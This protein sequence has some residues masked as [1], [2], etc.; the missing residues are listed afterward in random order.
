MS[1]SVALVSLIYEKAASLQQGLFVKKLFFYCLIAAVKV[2][3]CS[4]LR[5]VTVEV[6]MN[7]NNFAANVDNFVL[8]VYHMATD[9]IGL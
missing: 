4:F 5:S 2:S 8:M 3:I 6:K 1:R 9:L 7:I